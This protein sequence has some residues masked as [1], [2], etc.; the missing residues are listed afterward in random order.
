MGLVCTRGSSFHEFY[1]FLPN[2]YYHFFFFG[3]RFFLTTTFTPGTQNPHPRPT[4]LRAKSGKEWAR[5]RGSR[6][7]VWVWVNVMVKT[8]P[9]KI[10]NKNK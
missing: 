3:Q 1:N 8:F 9:I 10:K 6:V 2:F 4:T 7:G 5:E